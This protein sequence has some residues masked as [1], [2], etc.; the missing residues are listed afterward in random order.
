MNVQETW[1]KTQISDYLRMNFMYGD[2]MT[3]YDD[4]YDRNEYKTWTKYDQIL[5]GTAVDEMIDMIWGVEIALLEV[6]TNKGESVTSTLLPYEGL[7]IIQDWAPAEANRLG[8]DLDNM[9]DYFN[10]YIGGS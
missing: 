2:T 8:R 3:V 5:T 9:I 4:P 10:S 7:D 6:V 1:V